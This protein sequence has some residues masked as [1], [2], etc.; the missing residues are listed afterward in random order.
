MRAENA[1]RTSI[2]LDADERIRKRFDHG[3]PR[4]AEYFLNGERVGFRE[5]FPTG[6]LMREKTFKHGVRH[7]MDYQWDD[8]GV[9]L[10]AEPYE[11]GLPHST[12]CQWAHDGRLIGTYT[13]ERGTGIDLWRQDWSDRTVTLAEVHYMKDGRPHGYEWWIDYDQ[14]GVHSEQHWQEG[15]L[16]GIERQWNHEGKLTRGYPKYWVRNEQVDKRKYLRAAAKDPTLPPF[17][18]QDN[19]PPREFPPEIKVHLHPNPPV[20]E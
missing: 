8:P 20:M 10:S 12:A 14:K 9:L 18:S 3:G 1:Y 5:F 13:L 15:R 16:H 2:P 4:E 7:G 11:D 17:R 6:E 19:S